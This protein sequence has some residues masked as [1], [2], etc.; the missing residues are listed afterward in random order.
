MHPFGDLF[1]HFVCPPSRRKTKECRPHE[2]ATCTAVPQGVVLSLSALACAPARTHLVLLDPLNLAF[3]SSFVLPA[4]AGF[5]NSLH[6][7]EGSLIILDSWSAEPETH[8]IPGFGSILFQKQ[9]SSQFVLHKALR[10]V[11]FA[12]SSRD[13]VISQPRRGQRLICG[14]A[15]TSLM[16]A[17]ATFAARSDTHAKAR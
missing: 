4:T 14:P 13:L 5:S 12:R 1:R 15:V 7:Q 17:G 6:R 8:L 3:L 11:P 16:P 10:T 2:R 9:R